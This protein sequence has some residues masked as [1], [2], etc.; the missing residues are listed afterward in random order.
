MNALRITTIVL[1][2]I[3]K[4]APVALSQTGYKTVMDPLNGREMLVGEIDTASLAKAPFSEWYLQG[5]SSYQPETGIMIRLVNSMAPEYNYQI[6]MG[7]WCSDSHR[8]VPRIMKVLDELG[9]P[10]SHITL[11]AVDRNME[12]RHTPVSKMKISK[13]P[14]LIVGMNGRETGRIVE[15]PEA[16]VEEDLLRIL[17]GE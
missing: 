6:V 5:L 4:V 16:S 17:S 11:Y 9:V 7:T 13:V 8:E 2:L 10:A 14:T 3:L 15:S 12:A 1:I